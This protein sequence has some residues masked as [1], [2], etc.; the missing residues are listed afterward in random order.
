MT[1]AEA[2]ARAAFLSSEL[3]RH[4]R[5]YYIEAQPVISDKEFDLLLRELQDIEAQFP[6]LLTPDSPTQRVGGAALDGF[7]QIRHAVP[8]MS[9]DNTYSE[10]E[11]TAFFVR[12]QKGLGRESIECIIEPKVDG[13]AISVRYEDGVLKHGVTRGDG[14]TGDEVTNNL[15]TIKTLPLRLPTNGPQTFE[16]RGEVFMPK[17]GFAKLNQEREEAGESLFAN[18]RNSTAGT[19]KLLDPKIVAKRPLDIVFYGLADASGLLIE[20]QDDVRKLLEA[21]GLPKSNLLW[22]ANSAEGL[23]K[24]IR[25]LDELRKTLP[26]ET[27]GAVIKVNAFVDQRELGVTSKAPRWAIAYKYQPEQAET[28]ILAVDIQVGRTGALTPVAR[29][30]PVFVSGSTVS[31]AT[32]HNFE[33]IERKDIRVGDRVIIE[34]AGEIIPAVV[35]VKIEKRDGSEQRIVPPTHCPICGTGVHRDEE[36]VVIRC[37]NPKCPEVVKRRMEHFVSRAAMDISG[38]GESVVAQLVDL[39]LVGDVADLYAL[40]ELLLARL[41]RVGTKSIDNYLKAIEISK[42]QD[43]WRLIFGLGILHVGAGSARKLLEH[44]G[45]IDAMA[46]ASIEELMQCPDIGEIVAVSIHSWF[47]DAA[48]LELVDRLRASGLN[49]V[50]KA[51]QAASSKLAGTTWVITG[52]L[53]QERETIADTIRSHGGKVSGSVSGKTTY[54]LAGADAGSKLDKAAKLGVKAMSEEEFRAMIG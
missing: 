54:L 47:H 15:K 16:V 26:Y 9:L 46:K 17:A 39:R 20:S 49:L 41:E 33:E 27:D 2:A 3:H 29:L 11:L 6:D 51:V 22:H 53:S 1:H 18:P 14:T 5:L 52:T 31:N 24:A 37:P 25:Q 23:L 32:L 50:Q 45:S 36:Q 35:S 44:F 10:E 34:K 21:A 30:E 13:V 48:N 42:Q 40:N 12:V 38:L 7:T 28:Q 19:L 43:P 4:N 8:M